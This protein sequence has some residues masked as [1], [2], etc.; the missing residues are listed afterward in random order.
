MAARSHSPPPSPRTLAEKPDRHD[1][2]HSKRSHHVRRKSGNPPADKKKPVLPR[3]STPQHLKTLRSRD[4]ESHHDDDPARDAGE[5][6]PQFWYVQT[7]SPPPPRWPHR[8]IAFLYCPFFFAFFCGVQA[9]A[10]RTLTTC[11]PSLPPWHL[12]TSTP[13][14]LTDPR[15]IV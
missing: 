9:T 14:T 15:Y 7:S 3:R 8:R 2:N 4:R 11:C 10:T 12:P 6:F 5:S 13:R 1:H